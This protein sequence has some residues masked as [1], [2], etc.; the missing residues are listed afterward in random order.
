MFILSSTLLT[1]CY[2]LVVGISR[3]IPSSIDQFL[4]FRLF[5]ISML[6]YP[7]IIAESMA[8]IQEIGFIH[9]ACS[10]MFFDVF[11]CTEH[12][13]MIWVRVVAWRYRHIIVCGLH[14]PTITP[15]L[16]RYLTSP[17]VSSAD[18]LSSL[19]CKS[20]L[21]QPINCPRHRNCFGCGG[22]QFDWFHFLWVISS[23]IAFFSKI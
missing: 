9:L 23:S 2:I 18:F 7:I 17:T 19:F 1:G 8:S 20:M 3:V 16:T 21:T 6:V 11:P 12:T 13:S 5:V 15:H 4:K 14:I 10:Y 22:E